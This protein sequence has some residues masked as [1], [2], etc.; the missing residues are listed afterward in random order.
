MWA[1]IHGSSLRL[2]Q[3]VDPSQ[4]WVGSIC[5]PISLELSIGQVTQGKKIKIPCNYKPGPSLCSVSAQWM[6]SWGDPSHWPG[7]S[8][9]F[10]FTSWAGQSQ[11]QGILIKTS[12]QPQWWA[13]SLLIAEQTVSQWT[14]DCPVGQC[15]PCKS[16]VGNISAEHK[17]G[18]SW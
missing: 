5:V 7:P 2:K 4:L 6:L 12:F 1:S 8:A 14:S 18:L 13:F 15:S 16:R 9:L 11:Y 3:P 10:P 17:K